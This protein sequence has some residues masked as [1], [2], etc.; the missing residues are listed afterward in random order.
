[1]Q[2]I[3]ETSIVSYEPEKVSNILRIAGW[4]SLWTQIGLAVVS[5]LMLEFAIAGRS[6]SQAA[7]PA[8]DVG[9]NTATQTAVSGVGVGI[10]WAIAGI[11]VSLFSIYLTFRYTRFAK[12]LR[13]PNPTLRPERINILSVVQL[14]VIVGL[15]GLLVTIIG[16][17]STLGVLLAKSIAQPQGVAIY[18]PGR[19]IRSL[20]I[21]IAM[22]NMSGI[23][24]HFVGTAT[25]FGIF[26]WLHR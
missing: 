9:V 8:P 17:G 12:R 14:G 18:D 4:F 21:F 10:F 5:G 6:F 26:N 7:P 22:A 3:S 25:S 19:V 13:N 1:M 11:L 16:T 23:T 2:T 15:L 24:A 20:D